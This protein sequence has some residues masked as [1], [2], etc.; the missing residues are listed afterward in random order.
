M[1]NET[2]P[3][4]HES[5]V[6]HYFRVSR[7]PITDRMA[8]LMWVIGWDADQDGA[9]T[10]LAEWADICEEAASM[11]MHITIENVVGELEMWVL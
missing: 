7:L 3:T 10:K 5:V 1:A 4:V 6:N 2:L 8:K 9:E 11:E